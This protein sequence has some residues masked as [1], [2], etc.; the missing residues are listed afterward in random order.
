MLEMSNILLFMNMSLENCNKLR[1]LI[2][3]VAGKEEEVEI[4][5]KGK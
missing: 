2:H 1:Q 3:F 4:N 5:I